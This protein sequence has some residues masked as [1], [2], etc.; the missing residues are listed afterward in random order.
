MNLTAQQQEVADAD[1][2][3][4]LIA[5]PGSG[6]T[7]SAA[8]RVGRLARDGKKVAVC[9]YTNV[10]AERIGR[11]IN[12]DGVVL[13]PEHFLG[14]LH[15]FLLR[16]VV[17]PFGKL[18]EADSQVSVIESSRTVAYQGNNKRRISVDAFRMR[19]NGSLVLTKRPP[20]LSSVAREDIVADVKDEVVRHKRELLR[21]GCASY[22]DTM[23]F[24]LLI[25]RRNPEIAK[26]VAARFDEILLDEAQDTSELQLACVNVLKASGS[27]RSLV[28]VGDLEQSIFAFQGASADGCRKLAEDQGLR[29]V[30][31][32]QNHRCSQLICDVAAHFCE[33][34][35]P[36]E[37]VGRHAGCAV[38]PE[39]LFYPPN[40]PSKA[41]ERFQERLTEHGGHQSSAAVLARGNA[42]VDELNGDEAPVKVATR[43][44]QLGRAVAA[45]RHGTLT[46]R[47][48]EQV[49]RIVC[50]AA[51]DLE[52]LGG[53]DMEER[54]TLRSAVIRFLQRLP[55]LDEDLRAWI[56]QSASLLTDASKEVTDA[57]AHPGG[58]VL[59]SKA[60]QTGTIA[61]DAFLR[62][63]RPLEAQ[64]VHDIKGEDRDAVMVVIDRPRSQRHGPQA[65]LWESALAG[66]ELDEAQAEERRIAFVALTRAE[67]VCVVAL[68]DDP[69]GQAAAE[70]FV[71]RGFRLAEEAE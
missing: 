2:D 37:A 39:V 67:R 52:K 53:L 64:T 30:E 43:P 59:R 17:Y 16:Y 31:L 46:R 23:L 47:L 68:P 21:Q 10:G 33:R 12:D 70:V 51:W 27:L 40:E 62:P 18:L 20:Y 42:L 41:V 28:L 60:E 57:P 65:S 56:Q 13:G 3:F 19:P 35:E 61:R 36:D 48:L 32:T 7:R 22:D 8:S 66:N 15:G 50:Y 4:L 5:C 58:N 63:S 24:A 71:S 29:T 1:G 34:D 54:R 11:V 9:S 69:H 26:A 45:L 44:M 49:E 38:H 25:L 55:S 14:T 6:K